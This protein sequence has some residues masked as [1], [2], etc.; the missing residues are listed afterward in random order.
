[1][2]NARKKVLSAAI[3][4]RQKKRRERELRKP[5]HGIDTPYHFVESVLRLLRSIQSELPAE[6]RR[7]RRYRTRLLG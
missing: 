3:R 5:V 1:M 6:T 7:Y 4:L 2:S